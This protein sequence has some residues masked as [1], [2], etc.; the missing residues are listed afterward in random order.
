MLAAGAGGGRPQIAGGPEL[1]PAT[2]ALSAASRDIC[3]PVVSSLTTE[4]QIVTLGSLRSN[5]AR[6]TVTG[7]PYRPFLNPG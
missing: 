7:E 5:S 4:K 1:G 6:P 2:C 3:V